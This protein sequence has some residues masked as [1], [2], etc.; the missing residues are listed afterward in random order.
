MDKQLLNA[1]MELLRA[2]YEDKEVWADGSVDDFDE[3]FTNVF[4]TEDVAT[5]FTWDDQNDTFVA[6][7]MFDAV[8]STI[9][10]LQNEGKK[11]TSSWSGYL[12]TDDILVCVL[13]YK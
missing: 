10:D 6:D 11:V 1:K 13:A 7:E 5:Y 12:G 4:G 8:M 3:N 2:M 9:M